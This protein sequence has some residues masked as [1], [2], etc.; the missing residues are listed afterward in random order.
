MKADL[1][2]HSKY[3][4]G[5]YWP[6]ELVKMA[7]KI[8]LE[9]IALT[10]HDTFEGVEDFLKSTNENNIIGIPAIEIDFVDNTFS[11]KSE[12]L[13]YFPNGNFE[14]ISNYISHFQ[15]LRRKIVEIAIQKARIIYNFPNLDIIELIENKIGNS[16]YSSILNKISLTKPDIFKY[17]NDKNVPHSYTDYQHFKNEYFR[18][19]EFN[20][21]S[22]KPDFSKC[23]E[24]INKDCGYAVLAHPA[25][26]FKKDISEIFKHENEYKAK[27]I[28]AK[29][30]GL[31]GI[32][33]HSYESI[34]EADALN[35][36]FHSFAIDCGL[37]ITYG[38]DFHGENDRNT[39]RLGCLNKNFDGFKR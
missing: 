23:I 19:K 28:L 30:I 5:L 8:G 15:D 25:Y 1:H 11:F 26:Q 39:R 35:K 37:N 12:L 13:G 32:E 20:E 17:F 34:D 9:M 18:D 36:I 4:D 29:Q 16:F 31:W 2:F 6:D 24:L 10:D 3:S 38:S 27:L 33:M 14:N 22:A 21:L 7:S